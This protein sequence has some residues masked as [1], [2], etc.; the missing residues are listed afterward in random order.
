ME[1]D[2]GP[3]TAPSS[4]E[5]AAAG[6]AASEGLSAAATAAAAAAEGAAADSSSELPEGH[7]AAAEEGDEPTEDDEDPSEEEEDSDTGGAAVPEGDYSERLTELL[8]QAD[9]YSAQI[10]GGTAP[11]PST[12][13]ASST[14][15]HLLTEKEEDDLLLQAAQEEETARGLYIRITEQPQSIRGQ[16]KSYQIEGLNWLYQLFRLNINGILADEMG[17]GKTLQCISLL[18]FL[19]YERGVGGPHLII[20]PRST[21]DNWFAETAK[22]CPQLRAVRLHGTKEQREIIFNEEMGGDDFDICLTTYEMIIKERSRLSSKYKWEYL[23]MDEAHRIKN[24]KSI[25]AD[26]VRRF[27][28]R[29]RLLITG[30]PLQNNLRELWSL[31]NFIMPQVSPLNAAAAAAA[32]AVAAAAA[33]AGVAAA[34]AAAAAGVAVGLDMLL[35]LHVEKEQR[36]EQQQRMIQTLHRVLRPFMLRRLKTDVARD[37]PPKREVYIFVG[38]S[39]LQKKLYADILSKNL[40]VL[41]LMSS[42][43]TQML[44]ILMQ[45][46][47]CCMSKLQKKLYADILSKNLEVLSLMSSSKTQMLNI[48]MQLRKCCNHP[49]LFD[50]V[51]PGPPYVEGYHLV[52]AAGKMH[53]LDRLLPRLKAEG[54]RVL[55]FSQMTRLLDIVDDYCRWRGH[56]YC[57]IDGST[58]GE[59]RQQK[60][61]DFNREGSDKFL[62]LLSTRAGGLGINLATA[63]VVILFD[64]DFNPQMDLQAMDRAH[65]I[66]QKKKV[67]VYRFVT[68]STVEERIVERA[69]KKLKLD[70]LVIQKGRLSQRGPQQQQQGPQASELQEILQFGAQE[71]YRTQEESSITDAD[72]DII[73]ADAEQRTA[74]IEAQLQSLE[75]KFDLS[76]ISL[77]GGLHMYGSEG[78]PQPPG[79]PGRKKGAKTVRPTLL[80]DLG[81]RKTKWRGEGAAAAGAFLIRKER[82]L[83]RKLLTGWRAEI[84]GGY[85]FQFFNAE[86]LDALDAVQRKWAEW[87]LKKRQQKHERRQQEKESL[88]QQQQQQQQ[89]QQNLEGDDLHSEEGRSEKR[90]KIDAQALLQ[91]LL[92]EAGEDAA[93]AAAADITTPTQPGVEPLLRS[94]TEQQQKTALKVLEAYLNHRGCKD[95][96]PETGD[97][98][99]LLLQLLVPPPEEQQEQQEQEQQEQQ[100]QQELQQEADSPSK[101]SSSSSNSS[102]SSSSSSKCRWAV[103]GRPL[104]HLLQELLEDIESHTAAR[105]GV[106]LAVSLQQKREQVK[107]EQQEL[108]EQQQQEQD[109]QQDTQQDQE[110][111]QQEQQQPKKRAGRPRKIRPPEPEEGPS[112]TESAL[113][114]PDDPER[115]QPFTAEMK[116]QKE[117]L[118]SEGFLNWN[119]TEFTKFIS[120]LIHLGRDRLEEAWQLHFSSSNKTVED[121]RKY[122]DVFFKRYTEIEGGD[123]MMQRIERAEELRG[124]IDLQRRAIQATVEE[125]LLSGNVSSPTDLKLP[126]GLGPSPVFTKEEDC[127]LLWGLYEQGVNAFALVHAAGQA[128]QLL[129]ARQALRSCR[130]AAAAAAAVAAAPPAA[131][132]M[133]P[134]ASAASIVPSLS[135]LANFKGDSEQQALQTA[136]LQLTTEVHDL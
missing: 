6:A 1:V 32:A 99:Q 19:K 75:S 11:A 44:N 66:G 22:W 134:A 120:A 90:F 61:D 122:A 45:L 133:Q 27:S 112:D 59:E 127:L 33:D 40:E 83:A 125:Q 64:S 121:L 31:L 55:L 74:E 30:T 78:G 13:K 117:Q 129:R 10:T 25:L 62:F 16:M 88:M 20:C 77:D 102:S 114:D 115:P 124:A 89:Q 85:D 100:Q 14:R 71:V 118:L 130:A 116:M 35:V 48:L 94:L 72:I 63:D 57:R 86:R 98:L 110:Q 23:V 3:A 67:V 80:L 34:H 132:G 36:N 39:K 46:R 105:E 38:M 119:R 70:S 24:E 92:Q 12:K 5:G 2:N 103:G 26:V 101:E 81:D 111:Q 17:L 131:T 73:L 50:G 109:T 79:K 21:L 9:A 65:R 43:K 54:S 107:H 53:L 76:N 136:D 82:R 52:E 51:E 42:S 69:A 60:I 113:D 49:Y 56:A 128:P 8:R 7:I 93:A 108:S 68:G 106:P 29:H 96:K 135:S 37:L 28:P 87:L 15:S 104:E 126:A 97:T 84:N 47:K 4:L 58:P 18:A 95:I 41:S 91:Q 123:R